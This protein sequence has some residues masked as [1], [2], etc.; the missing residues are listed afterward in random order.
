MQ[1]DSEVFLRR[2]LDGG[3]DDSD[4]VHAGVGG[5]CARDG[6]IDST[7]TGETDVS[8]AWC[9]GDDEGVELPVVEH[10]PGGLGGVGAQREPNLLERGGAVEDGVGTDTLYIEAVPR[11]VGVDGAVEVGRVG[12]ECDDGVRCYVAILA[13]GVGFARG[14]RYQ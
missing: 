5:T 2:G 9:V 10:E 3:V 4:A 6:V 14:H 13:G 1:V 8:G 12:G 7:A 11:V